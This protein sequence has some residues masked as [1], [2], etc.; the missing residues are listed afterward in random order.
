MSDMG[1]WEEPEVLADAQRTGYNSPLLPGMSHSGQHY[2]N[3][4]GQ[5]GEQP[6]QH[7][8]NRPGQLGD[9]MS[10]AKAALPALLVGV[11]IGYFVCPWI[12]KKLSKAG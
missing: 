10:A 12:K 11:A 6:A 7:Y 4:P 2:V 3:R 8:V 1:H 5:L 9:Y